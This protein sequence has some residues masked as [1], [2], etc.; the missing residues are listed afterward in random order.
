MAE[1]DRNEFDQVWDAEEIPEQVDEETQEETEETPEDDAPE[2]TPETEE[3]VTEDE[4]AEDEPQEEGEVDESVDWSKYGLDNFSGKSMAEVAEQIKRERQSLGHTT[5]MLGDL[6]KQLNELKREPKREETPQKPKDVFESI[7]DLSEED[8]AK[9]NALY[10]KNPVKAIM[11][12]GG[13]A[14]IEQIIADKV[15]LPDIDSKLEET[16]DKVEFNTFIASNPDVTDVDI[17]QMKIFDD[18]QYL[19]NQGRTYSDLY[20]LARLWRNKDQRAEQIYM[21]MKK[22]P[23]MTFTEADKFVPKVTDKPDKEKI[24]STV[25]KNKNNKTKPVPVATSVVKAES[26][27]DAWDEA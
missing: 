4:V 20:G 2:E 22:H 5:N 14:V 18:E 15:K 13:K 27:E 25:N 7:N 8:T 10:E 24:K 3:E 17:E 26:F 21:L 1:N 6:R 12:Y 19:G 9:F 16:K 11:T 23:T